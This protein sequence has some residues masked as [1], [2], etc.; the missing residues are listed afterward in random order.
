M[1]ITPWRIGQY[2]DQVNEV[3]DDE[4]QDD[5]DDD[6][7]DRDMNSMAMQIWRSGP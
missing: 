5:E 6:H 1:K 7:E 3:E 4:D 2:E